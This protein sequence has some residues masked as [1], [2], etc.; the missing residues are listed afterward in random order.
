MKGFGL[1]VIRKDTRE[2]Q[3][4]WANKFNPKYHQKIPGEKPFYHGIHR[5][6]V[7]KVDPLQA[8]VQ[9]AEIENDNKED[10]VPQKSVY[11]NMKMPELKKLCKEKGIKTTFA[12]KKVDLVKL[13][14]EKVLKSEND[15]I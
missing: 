4:I 5:P 11:D 1:K 14:E 7:I 9:K 12:M 15:T 3:L 2:V 13:L 8:A 6:I 10:V